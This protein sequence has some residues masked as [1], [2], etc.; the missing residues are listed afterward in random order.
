MDTSHNRLNKLV[1]QLTRNDTAVNL[2]PSS[3]IPKSDAARMYASRQIP[4]FKEEVMKLLEPSDIPSISKLSHY[5]V[6]RLQDSM[7]LQ[8]YPNRF[9][10]TRNGLCATTNEFTYNQFIRDGEVVIVDIARKTGMKDPTARCMIRAGP[11]ADIVWKRGEVKAAI[12]TCGGL[13]PGLNDVVAAIWNTLY[14][15][16]GVDT[17]YG[18]RNGF[19][20]FWYNEYRPWETL[21]P[22]NTIGIQ[23]LGGTILG[24]S[25]GGFDEAK[26]LESCMLHGVNQLY[27]IGGDGTHR[28]A[29]VLAEGAIKRGLKMCVIGVPKTI[30]NDVGIIDRSFGF[31]TAVAHAKLAVNS[32]FVEAKCTPNGIGV[33]KLM[34]RHAGYITAHAT[35]ASGQVDCAIIPEIRFPMDGPDGLLNHLETVLSHQKYAVVV[36]AEGGGSHLL[37]GSGAKDAGGNAVLPEIGKYLC[38]VMQTHFKKKNID[39]SI[40]YHDPSYMIRSVPANADDSIYCQSIAQNAVHGGMAGYTAFTSGLVNNRT[41]L[42]PMKLVTATS[43]SFLNPLGR[44]WERVLS[45]THQPKWTKN[46]K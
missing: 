4:M 2:D 22:K 30:D 21:T 6:P 12:V 20:G 37:E 17:I 42:L 13:C 38:D 16:Y 8:T 3:A 32:A 31:N 23:N 43:P 45:S 40:K 46:K 14:Y 7:K 35:L 19:R 10:R 25:R 39:A 34:G 28:A 36:V 18:I 1:S 26:I 44:T 24:S 15:N 5:A 41:V 29:T 27:I 9:V 33:V 11:R